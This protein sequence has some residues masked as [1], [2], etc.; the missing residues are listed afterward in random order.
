MIPLTI[1]VELENAQD[2]DKG[3]YTCHVPRGSTS[4]TK[5]FTLNLN[6]KWYHS[7]YLLIG[8]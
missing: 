4:T 6:S 8:F 1:K 2:E 3:V 5:S 7:P